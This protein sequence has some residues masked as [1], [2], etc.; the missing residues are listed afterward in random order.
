MAL[1]LLLTLLSGKKSLMCH[2][3]HVLPRQKY[4]DGFGLSPPFLK[5]ILEFLNTHPPALE[6]HKKGTIRLTC[7]KLKELLTRCV[8]GGGL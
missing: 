7:M 1:I 2:M 3:T 5:H 8:S 6:K 4:R